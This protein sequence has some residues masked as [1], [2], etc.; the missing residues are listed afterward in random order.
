MKKK[1]RKIM[2][3]QMMKYSFLIICL[4]VSKTFSQTHKASVSA[5]AKDGLH[6]ILLPVNIRAASNDNFNFLRVKNASQDEIPYVL[7]YVTDKTF[8]EFIPLEIAAKNRIKDSITS[9]L[10]ENKRGEIRDNITLKIANTNIA[11]SYTVYGS[12]NQKDWFGLVANKRLSYSNKMNTTVLEKTIHFPLNDYKFLKIAFNDTNSLPINILEAGVYK[13]KFFTQE[14]LEISAN[15]EEQITT[16]KDK[17]T[18]QLKFTAKDAHKIDVISFD[19]DT[20]FFLRKAKV[21][22][23]RTRNIKKRIETYDQVLDQFQL[24]SQNRNTFDIGNLNVKEFRI[25]IENQDNPPLNIEKVQ[26]FQKPVHVIANLKAKEVYEVVVDTNLVKP[27]YDLGNFIS[28]QTKNVKS[29]VIT[30][31]TKL[32]TNTQKITEHKSFWETKTFMWVCIVLGGFF[33]VY[34]ALGLLKDIDSEK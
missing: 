16:I 22:V 11:K 25:E 33:V 2:K 18:T 10:I 4:I 13:S 24:N 31:V 32:E 9:V 26:F 8:S 29:A 20:D 6:K 7:L 1:Q 5:I 27:S 21:I 15:F 14:A 34:F 23:T 19:I 12:D 3:P 17:K 28:S 30:T